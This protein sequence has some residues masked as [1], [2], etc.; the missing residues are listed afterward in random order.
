MIW[1][2]CTGVADDNQSY[3]GVNS[4]AS[5]HP[6]SKPWVLVVWKERQSGTQGGTNG[7]AGVVA[8]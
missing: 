8:S 3:L 1:K 6:R 7:Y 5:E 2:C 4:Y